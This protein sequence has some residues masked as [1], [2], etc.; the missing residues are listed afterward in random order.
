MADIHKKCLLCNSPE[1]RELKLYTKDFLI[2]CNN[3]GF[4]FCS[5]IPSSEE[6]ENYYGRYI[7]NNS[8]SP[9]T[10]SRYNELLDKFEKYRK[11]N[12]ILDVGCGD[13]YFLEV[14][15][16][17][18][19]NVFGT[20]YTNEAI[21]V[22]RSKKIEIFKGE[23]NY[24]NFNGIEFDVVTSFEVIEHINNP[25]EVIDNILK[26]LRIGGA[27]YFTTPNFNSIN[28]RL[29]KSDWLIIEYP[30]HLSYYTSSTMNKFLKSNKFSKVFLKTQGLSISGFIKKSKKLN[31]E[32]NNRKSDENL[33]TSFET[34]FFRKKIK[35]LI[36]FTL[37]FFKFGDTLKGLYVKKL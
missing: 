24:S 19:W 34:S 8:I 20:E 29:L 36:N 1:L 37:N 27:L 17:R 6:L 15:R 18:G 2:K 5:K 10:I 3:C 11:T 9:I 21:G 13:G 26:L 32:T 22:C 16:N 14:A 23:L 25:K 33:R 28:R 7:R 35:S 12:N 31:T 4:I 30:E